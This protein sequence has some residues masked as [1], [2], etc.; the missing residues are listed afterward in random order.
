M[1]NLTYSEEK[2][3]GAKECILHASIYIKLQEN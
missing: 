2:K 3:P 1:S